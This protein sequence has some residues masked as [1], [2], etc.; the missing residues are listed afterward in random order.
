VS[1]A[2][3]L[4]T[5]PIM[6]W[7]IGSRTLGCDG[8]GW[9]RIDWNNFNISPAFSV[10]PNKSA[11]CFSGNTY[12]MLLAAS[13][14]FLGYR[15]WRYRNPQTTLE[16]FSAPA[17]S[18]VA[19]SY[20]FIMVYVVGMVVVAGLLDP[21]ALPSERYL[22]P[23]HI[24]V[25]CVYLSFVDML[26]G[27]FFIENFG[28]ND[29]SSR[30]R[31]VFI[32]LISVFII[33]QSILVSGWASERRRQGT[34]LDGRY[35]AGSEIIQAVKQIPE[36]SIIYSNKA[37]AV[38]LLSGRICEMVDT[39]EQFE[40]PKMAGKMRQDFGGKKCYFVYCDPVP[41]GY[42]RVEYSAL[43]LGEIRARL[44]LKLWRRLSD[45]AIYVRDGSAP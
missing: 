16:Q 15:L 27:P 44:S 42:S 30:T 34:L 29:S 33:S 2:V 1:I 23:L 31:A 21:D 14:V 32:T 28:L 5:L 26:A 18:L 41:P 3:G 6:V 43:S 25:V 45:G 19:V 12:W 22:L 17:R 10:W 8:F 20:I 9:H 7:R 40:D 36:N 13:I 38:Y 37:K 4:A 39:P 11:A 35:W 24:F